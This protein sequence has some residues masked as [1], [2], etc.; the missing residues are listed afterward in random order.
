MSAINIEGLHFDPM[1]PTPEICFNCFIAIYL[2]LQKIVADM[3]NAHVGD[4][5]DGR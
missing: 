1:S 3:V 5:A 4:W 2:R